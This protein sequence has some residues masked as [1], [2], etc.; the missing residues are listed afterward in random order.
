MDIIDRGS[1]AALVLV[2]GIQGRWEYVRPAVDVLAASARVLTFQLCGERRSEQR[3][4]RARG[5]DQD[6]DQIVR[7]LED[8]GIRRAVICGV[9]FGGLIA[10]RFAAIH[11]NRTAGLILA[12]TPGPTF[13]LSGR[14]Q[15]YVRAPR[16]FGAAFLAESPLRLRREIAA[17]LPRWRERRRFL[18]WQMSTLVTAP[19]S[20][21]RMASRAELIAKSDRAAD[22]RLIK[23]PTLIITGERALDYIVPVGGTSEYL[24]LIEHVRA[25]TL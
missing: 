22:A 23:S 25:A 6:V 8:R 17:A 20:I 5:L 2:P 21:W 3:L 24:R 14:H 19:L 9:S 4:D 1:G 13:Q 11:P 18:L 7:V 12:S 10:L 16:L 15:L